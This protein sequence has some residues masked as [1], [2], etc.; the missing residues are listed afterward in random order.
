MMS[1][2]PYYI[3]ESYGIGTNLQLYSLRQA[4]RCWQDLTSQKD[5]V[6]EGKIRERCVVIVDLLGLSLSQLLGQNTPHTSPRIPA[7]RKLLPV[8]LDQT[9]IPEAQKNSLITRFNDFLNTYDD[10]RHFGIPK[11][12]KLNNLDLKATESFFNL[13]IQIWDMVIEHFRAGREDE[14]CFQSSREILDESNEEEEE[15]DL[16]S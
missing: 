1:S 6:G 10:C 2:L 9:T 13:A 15:S 14:V 8:F 12:E 3:R 4:W 16:H 7:P 11:H 5:L